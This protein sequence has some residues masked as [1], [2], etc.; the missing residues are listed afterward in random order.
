M[1]SRAYRLSV[2]NTTPWPAT[3]TAATAAENSPRDGVWGPG[4][5]PAQT[6]P[7]TP[8]MCIARTALAKN[9]SR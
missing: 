3:P 5:G 6:P 2:T 4:T 7:R 1:P 9:G 8:G